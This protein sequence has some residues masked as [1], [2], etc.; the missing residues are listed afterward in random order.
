[1]RLDVLDFTLASLEVFSQRD[2]V[3]QCGFLPDKQLT[4]DSRCGFVCPSLC[5]LVVLLPLLEIRRDLI[6][7]LCRCGDFVG[8]VD[9]LVGPLNNVAFS[10][11]LQRL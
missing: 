5:L 11:R 8:K 10:Q 4:D 6:A 2:E 1:L 9:P 7:V 3:R